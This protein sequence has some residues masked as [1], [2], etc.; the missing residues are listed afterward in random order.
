M[1]VTGV[2]TCDLPISSYESTGAGFVQFDGPVT[3]TTGVTVTTA[4]AAGDN[5]TFTDT[6]DSDGTA[7]ALTLN[8]GAAGNVDVQG[9][10]GLG[11]ALA[12]LTVDGAQIDLA[13]VQATGN[14]DVAGTA[15][16]L[17]G[18]SYESTGAGFVQFDGP[19]T[20]TTGV[21][22]T[23]A[24]AAGDNITFTDTVDSDGTAR[25]L[26]L[27]AGA[28][29]NVDVQG[30]A[31]LGS[32]LASL[33]VDGA[34]I[35]L[36]S[37]QA[38]GNIDVAGTAINLNGASYESTGAGFVQF[39]GPVTLTTG[40]TVTTAG[41]AGD[42]I[43]FTDTVD[44]DGT[45]RAL[46]LNAGAAGNVDVQGDAGL[47]SALASLTVDGAQIDLASVQAT[48]NI[49]VA[50]TAINLNGASYE[51]TGAGF[52]QFDGPVTLTTGVTV[53]TA[54]AAGDN[55]TFTDTVDSD[56]T[57]RALTLNAGAAGNVDVQ[58]SEE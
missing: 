43:T 52:V 16:N 15:I 1:T 58:R 30:D 8:A 51:S 48:G 32:A 35:D 42:N 3:L 55:I 19:V 27:N 34:Q 6:V 2:Q 47:G 11:S 28:A 5:I 20:L 56:G 40:V 37:V 44:S 45:A 12:S 18:A 31:G 53:T 17:N 46:T 26:T 57:A 21:T 13:S 38:T 50:G 14:I 4:G 41:A 25:A 54:G 36:A 33:T 29:G 9:D 23:T 24:G 10:A 7:R 49:D 22:V 39:D